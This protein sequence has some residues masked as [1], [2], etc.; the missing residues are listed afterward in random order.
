[1]KYCSPCDDFYIALQ[2]D[3]VIWEA[4]DK[5][6]IQSPGGQIIYIK[7]CPFCGRRLR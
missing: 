6:Y 2:V 4:N 5:Y 1:M 3:F 7:Y